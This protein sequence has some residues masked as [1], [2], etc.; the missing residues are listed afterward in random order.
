MWQQ[1]R[2]RMR[3]SAID[4]EA[5][6]QDLC[7]PQL[8]ICARFADRHGCT[9]TGTD[10]L[11]RWANATP[12]DTRGSRISGTDADCTIEQAARHMFYVSHFSVSA[13]HR[14]MRAHCPLPT[15][16]VYDSLWPRQPTYQCSFSATVVRI[17]FVLTRRTAYLQA[18]I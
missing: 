14:S 12:W 13:V 18:W 2:L 6:D 17:L 4:S 1:W 16:L 10:F 9:D 5:R 8:C 3:Q 15:G 7:V 11:S